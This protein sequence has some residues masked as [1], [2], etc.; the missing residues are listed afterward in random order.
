MKIH[1]IIIL[2]ALLAIAGCKNAGNVIRLEQRSS[3][4][5][6]SITFAEYTFPVVSVSSGPSLYIWQT[7]DAEC[8]IQLKGECITTNTTSALAIYNSSENKRMQF[9]GIVTARTNTIEA[10]SQEP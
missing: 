6:T 3:A 10:V 9:E 4:G 1:G 5:I 2:S 8:S 7:K